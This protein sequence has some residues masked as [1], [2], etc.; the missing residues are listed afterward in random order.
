[1]KHNRKD[2]GDVMPVSQFVEDVQEG[3]FIDDDGSGYYGLANFYYT[4]IPAYPSEIKTGKINA[5][6]PYVH[7]FNK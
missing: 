7:W 6:L 5:T 3:M 1:M 2:Y 4:N